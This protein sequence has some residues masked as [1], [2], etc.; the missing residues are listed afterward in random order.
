MISSDFKAAFR[1]I[2]RNKVTS[3]ISI[4]GLGIGLGCIINLM[5]L[6]FHEKSFDRFI[7]DYRNVYRILSGPSALSHYPLPEQMKQEFQEVKDYFR[8]YEAN[9][10]QVK[11]PENEIFRENDFGFADASI[12]GIMGIKFISGNAATSLNEVAISDE[13]A[14]K[15]FGNLSPV[16]S[17]FSV[18]LRKEFTELTVSG[19]YKSFPSNSTLYPSFVADIKLYDMIYRQSQTSLGQF[20]TEFS[21]AFT[22]SNPAFMSFIVLDRNSDPVELGEKMEKYKELFQKEPNEI[23]YYK[24]QPVS[25]IYLR[26][27]EISGNHYLRQ[28]NPE[29]LTYYRIISLLILVIAMAN[30]ILLTRAGVVERVPDLGTRK[31]FGAS[32]NDIR[33]LIILESNLVVI[34]SLIPASFVIDY[35]TRFINSALNKTMTLQVFRDPVLWIVLILVVT[36]TGTVSGW[37]IGL[38]YSKIPALKLITGKMHGSGRAG[39]W[40]YSFLVLHFSIYMILVTGVIGVSKQIKYLMSDYKGINYDNVLLAGFSTDNLKNSFNTLHDEMEKVPGVIAAAGGT[41]VPPLGYSVPINLALTDGESL[42]FDGLIMGEG[43][44]ELL[45]IEVIDGSSFGPYKPGTP[46]VLINESTA[47]EHNVK[48]GEFL[49]AFKVRGIVRDFNAHSL[50]DLIQPMV[51]LQQN[52]ALMRLIAIKTNGSNDEAVKKRLRELFTQLSPD[53]IFEVDYLTSWLDDLYVNEKNQAKIIGAFALLA[54]ILSI[55]GLFGISL[56]TIARRSK[57][58]GLRKVNGASTGEVL[59]LVNY[60]FLKWVLISA[61]IAVPVSVFLL[62]RWME[63]FAYRTELSWWIFALAALSAIIIAILTV[64]WQSLRAATSNPVKAIR[65]E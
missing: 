33:R 24:L 34:L 57:E 19:V 4:F 6:I 11:T 12:F 60:D 31:A 30:Y 20:G 65:Y 38:Y 8:Y 43:M 63:R 45:G 51:I 56:I 47:K 36:V 28:G 7:P 2:F 42:R 44:T 50:H 10:L 64:S 14:M 21:K 41:F 46:E 18:L 23:I 5:A 61:I 25:E 22:W 13:A 32:Y 54:T 39:K 55:M 27:H 49:L 1:N 40:N 16:G 53:E 62:N 17:V 35:G 48:A 15:Y 29:E 26:S 3:L 58:V 9:T 52:P 59:R 37:L